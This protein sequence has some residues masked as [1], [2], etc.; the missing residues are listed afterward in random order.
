MEEDFALRLHQSLR[1]LLTAAGGV[2]VLF[3]LP[4]AIRLYSIPGSAG[5]AVLATL[6]CLLAGAVAAWSAL[7]VGELEDRITWLEGTLDAVPQ[8]IT[9]TDLDMRWVYINK[10]TAG[11]LKRTREQVRGRH[12]SEWKADICN[13]EKCGIRSLRDGRPQT[14]FMQPL[15]D[16]SQHCMQVDTSY[17]QDRSGRRIGHVEIVTDI[18]AKYE[19]E[20]MYS[21]IAGSVEEMSSVMVEME[22]QTKGNADGASKASRL[23]EDSR[24]LV[25]AGNAQMNRLVE[26]MKGIGESSRKILKINKVIDEIA[27]QTNILALNAAVEAARA[28][29]SGAGFAVVADEVRNL[30][31]RVSTASMETSDLIGAAESS[32]AQGAQLASEVASSL[33]QID[34]SSASMDTLLGEIAGASTEQAKGISAVSEELRRMEQVTVAGG[35]AAGVG[36]SGSTRKRTRIY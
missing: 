29:E 6:G 27:F 16:G 26:A 1:T 33:S 23:A 15:P 9:V 11:L 28:G 8:P 21:K 19:A 25:Q 14:T 35:N 13:T 34:E 3:L 22:A 31:A 20:N 10:V 36:H 18:H 17:I 30:A 24:K 7:K 12:C 5:M 32:V 4:P 2:A